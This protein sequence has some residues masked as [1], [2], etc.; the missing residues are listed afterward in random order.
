VASVKCFRCGMMGHYANHCQN[1]RNARHVA[2]Q[3]NASPNQEELNLIVRIDSLHSTVNPE[4]PPIVQEFMSS[5]VL[6][7]YLLNTTSS[8]CQQ[9]TKLT[10]LSVQQVGFHLSWK[11]ESS[12]NLKNGN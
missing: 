8:Y 11:N 10:Q 9:L 3:N 5:M 2:P 12:R 7:N 1:S 4:Q 6:V